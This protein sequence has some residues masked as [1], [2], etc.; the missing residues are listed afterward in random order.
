[1]KEGSK[2]KAREKYPVLAHIERMEDIRYEDT[3]E[4]RPPFIQ[5]L[6]RCLDEND[7]LGSLR[8]DL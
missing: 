2:M 8:G 4:P 5:E 7:L 1:M 6:T 3:N